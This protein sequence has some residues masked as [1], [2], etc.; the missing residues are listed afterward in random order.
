MLF[1]SCMYLIPGVSNAFGRAWSGFCGNIQWVNCLYFTAVSL[2]IV[3]VS[4]FLAPVICYNYISLIVYAV[5]YGVF[6]GE[7]IECELAS[8]WLV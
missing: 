1:C 7:K 8:A 5:I 3:G 2:L 4:T 6:I